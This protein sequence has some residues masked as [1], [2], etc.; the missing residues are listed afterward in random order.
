MCC[1]QSLEIAT[2][3]P[4]PMAPCTRRSARVLSWTWWIVVSSPS[5]R[6]H[7]LRSM[8]SV[9]NVETVILCSRNR[10]SLTPGI[11][12]EACLFIDDEVIQVVLS[13]APDPA[14]PSDAVRAMASTD[15]QYYVKAVDLLFDPHAEERAFSSRPDY[16]G[17]FKLSINWIQE[18]YQEMCGTIYDDKPNMERSCP[19]PY[20]SGEN[21][22][23]VR[24]PYCGEHRS[25]PIGKAPGN[26]TQRGC[27]SRGT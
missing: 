24:L 25:R 16:K 7:P 27:G 10:G 26:G 23:R 4:V 2:R 15:A 14:R 17:W 22:T 13:Q 19:Y 1:G 21:P 9:R 6:S 3:R 12:T 20:L 18:F 11:L 5:Q 8:I